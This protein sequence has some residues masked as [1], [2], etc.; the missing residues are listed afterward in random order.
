M[1]TASI[2]NRA[3]TLLNRL[4]TQLFA[5][6][7][8]TAIVLQ[9][10]CS[11]NQRL[12]DSLTEDPA[13]QGVTEIDGL[14]YFPQQDDQCG[15]AS[16]ATMLAYNQITTTPEQLRPS[17]YIPKK[18]GTLAVE[19]EARARQF[20][21]IV[22]PL[23]PDVSDILLELD[24]GHPVLVMQNLGFSWLPQ[25]HFAVAIGYDLNA[26]QILLRSGPDKRYPTDLSLFEKTW[27]RADHWARVILSPDQLPAT[28]TPLRYTAAVN[29][30][31]QLGSHTPALQQAAARAYQTALKQW[32]DNATALMGLGNIDYAR[33]HYRS[34]ADYFIRYINHSNTPA[35][36]WNNLAYTLMQTGCTAAAIESISC[37]VAI[38]PDQPAYRDSLDELNNLSAT[39][40][41]KANCS[42]P[43]C[44]ASK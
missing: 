34:A 40:N 6:L 43:A 18:G 35:A 38:A 16:L 11:S 17:L 44:I 41:S 27:S 7:L 5:A 15:P 12:I 22:Y 32:P 23:K 25:W 4:S 19:M 37:A 42:L 26:Q 33:K 30:L 24:A 20:N 14:A 10:G 29:K 39:Q 2:A 3:D 31:E 1:F 8:L 28:A 21:L 36:G 13:I 9:T